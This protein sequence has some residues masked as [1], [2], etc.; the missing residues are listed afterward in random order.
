MGKPK[1]KVRLPVRVTGIFKGVKMNRKEMIEEIDA[2]LAMAKAGMRIS[3]YIQN[4]ILPEFKDE[5][6]QAVASAFFQLGTQ[7]LL[8]KNDHRM[9]RVNLETVVDLAKRHNDGKN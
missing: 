3:I 2:A 7:L 8:E 1:Q 4:H 9:L 5:S 6:Y